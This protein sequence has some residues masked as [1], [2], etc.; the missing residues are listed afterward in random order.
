MNNIIKLQGFRKNESRMFSGREFGIEVRCKI[1]LDSRDQD[2][3]TY[4]IQISDDTMAINSS[5]FG[6]LFSES[7]LTLGAERFREK[8]IFQNEKGKSLKDTLQK[9]IEEGIYDTLNS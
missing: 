5:F 2:F 6:G 7:V 1:D 3:E 8:Y 4:Y 9:D